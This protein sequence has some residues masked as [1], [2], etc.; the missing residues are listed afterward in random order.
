MIH[1]GVV[2]VQTNLVPQGTY[3]KP[4]LTLGTVGIGLKYKHSS[5][6]EPP[7]PQRLLFP[8]PPTQYLPLMGVSQ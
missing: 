1:L 7:T 5:P 8:E 6:W 2:Q 3:H 4:F